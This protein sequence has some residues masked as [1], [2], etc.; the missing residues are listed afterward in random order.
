MSC[1][2]SRV[3]ESPVAQADNEKALVAAAKRGDYAA[4]EGLVNRTEKR[5]YRLGLNIT[6]SREDAE[7][8]LQETFLKAFE[9]LDD[10]REESRFYTWLVR[11]AINVGLMKL[12][13][14]RRDK[15]APLE[16]SVD[17]EGK[18]MPQEF[19]DWKPNPEE[20]LAQSELRATLRE[21]I[22]ALP[23]GLRVVFVLRA[24]EGFSTQETAEL[25]HLTVTAVKPRQFRA[26]L[27]LRKALNNI[28][29][30]RQLV[31]LPK[32]K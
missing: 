20:I 25:L 23:V 31:G 18:V 12:R 26:C 4:F 16:D 22:E 15:S 24:V 19:A 21:A 32:Q 6:G 13:K 17:D 10:F 5:I 2:S 29:K 3:F 8:V 11:I 14:R 1:S 7:E 9:H 30:E 28:F 27:R